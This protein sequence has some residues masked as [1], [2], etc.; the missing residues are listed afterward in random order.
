MTVIVFVARGSTLTAGSSGLYCFNKSQCTNHTFRMKRQLVV[1]L[2]CLELQDGGLGTQ[3]SALEQVDSGEDFIIG[4][5]T[6]HL[7]V[8]VS[9][10]FAAVGHKIKP[11]VIGSGELAD[12]QLRIVKQCLVELIY[13]DDGSC[14]FFSLLLDVSPSHSLLIISGRVEPLTEVGIRATRAE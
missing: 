9:A 4:H 11:G 3:Y 13:T 7:V 14:G 8:V 2:V 12:I 5:G 1:G 10:G 6:L